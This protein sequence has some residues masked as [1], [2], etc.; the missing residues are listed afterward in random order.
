[1]VYFGANANLTNNR[2]NGEKEPVIMTNKKQE[3]WTDSNG[4]QMIRR[5]QDT[6]FSYD[7]GNGAEIE[8]VTSNYYPINTGKVFVMG[9]TPKN[10]KFSEMVDRK[11]IN[12]HPKEFSKGNQMRSASRPKIR[13]FDLDGL[14]DV[15]SKNI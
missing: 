14:R 7:I 1:M 12:F 10:R 8:P 2:G 11:N 9:V 3:F 15:E 5:V 4:R 13:I 6:R